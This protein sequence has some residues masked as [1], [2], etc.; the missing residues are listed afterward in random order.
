MANVDDDSVSRIDPK[1]NASVDTI[2]V[3]KGPAGIAVGGGFVW[4]ANGLDGTVSK[5]DPS[6]N[7]PVQTI[8][9]GNGPSG[10]AFGEG[11]VWVANSTDRTVT[12]INPGTGK[13][14]R[15][16]P[17]SAGADGI[18]AGEGSVW[19]TSESAGTL[20]R[21]DPRTG[22]SGQPINVGSGAHAVAVGPG[23]V[24]VANNLDG[25]ASRID[26][27]SNRQ[28]SVIT[29]GDGPSGVAVTADGKTVWVSSEIAGTLSQIVADRVTHIVKTGNR[30]EDVAVSGGTL[31]VAVRTSGLAHRGGTLTV[32]ATDPFD[33]IDPAA[34]YGSWSALILTNDGLVAY[35]RVGG[36]DGTRLVPDLATSMPTPTD[37]GKTYTFQLRHGIRYSNGALVQPADFRR[38]IERSVASLESRGGTGFYYSNIVGYAAC[39]K[40]PTRCNL[41][42][43]I[44]TDPVSNTLTFHLAAPDPDFLFKLALPSAYAVPV[45][46]PLKARLPL[47]ATG[48]YMFAGNQTKRGVRLVRNPRFQVWNRAAQP[49]GYPDELAWRF[50]V[51]P[52]AQRRAVGQDK[53]DVAADAGA[54]TQGQFPPPALLP[55]LREQHASQLKVNPLVNAYY[56]FLNTRVAPF[57]DVRVRRA[58]NY[59]V[60]RNRMVDLRG[61]PELQQPSCQVLPPNIAG[62]RRYCPYTIDPRPDGRYTGPDLV[63]AR[64][65]VAASGTKGQ[66]VTVYG[67]TGIFQ[68]HGGDYFVSVLRNLGYKARFKNIGGADEYNATVADSRRKIQAGIGGWYSDYP[69]AANFLRDLLSCSSFVPSSASNNNRA[70]FC[71][72]RIDA[73]IVRA[74]ALQTTDPSAASGLWRKIDHDVVDQAPWVTLQNS[75]QVD[76][77]SRRVGN[78]QYNPQWG[79]LLG[80]LWVR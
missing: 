10:V 20:T 54:P 80:Q 21:I 66:E 75:Q 74:L 3:G 29:V 72:P 43:G 63:K 78:Y 34:A 60:D 73:E 9:V 44:V 56:V 46:T 14:G 7:T 5:I 42:K 11:A 1:T 22:I 47:P 69:S 61:G 67:I 36:S 33:S 55:T 52:D 17:A 64:R 48:P 70:E 27:A 40:A 49:D 32:L 57:N 15:E 45:G 62:Y 26:P 13:P 25:T 68:P 77:V 39:L 23:A 6:T 28:T 30:P 65:L 38:G 24:W 18:A 37:E 2:H 12:R 4:V 58:I 79:A 59:A 71:N 8:Q 19:V 31:Y 51:R 35:K 76:F 53:A 41:S 50:N 16:I